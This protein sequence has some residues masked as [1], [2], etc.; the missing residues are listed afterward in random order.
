M[1]DKLAWAK[2]QRANDQPTIPS[3]I[4]AG[5]R[6]LYGY[7]Q[8]QHPSAST[9]AQAVA[10][11]KIAPAAAHRPSPPQALQPLLQGQSGTGLT[12]VGCAPG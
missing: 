9:K 3:T 1:T 10:T 12:G 2:N 6:I 11:S 4:Q 7:C 8:S 5:H